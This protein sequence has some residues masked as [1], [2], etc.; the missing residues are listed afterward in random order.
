MLLALFTFPVIGA[1][2]SVALLASDE[3]LELPIEDLLNVKITSVSKKSQA[4]SDAAAAVFVISQ[5]DI[6]RSGVT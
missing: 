3:M 6:K 1:E 2:S 4:L 5:D